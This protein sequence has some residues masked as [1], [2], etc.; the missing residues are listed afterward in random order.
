MTD[1]TIAMAGCGALGSRIA[2]ELARPGRE[3]TL[4]DDDVIEE[5]NLPT[6][7]FYPHHVGQRK[8]DSLIE[9]LYWRSGCLSRT[10]P[11][12]L[13]QG[14]LHWFKEASLVVVTFDNAEARNLCNRLDVPVVQVG[15]SVDTGSVH[16]GVDMDFGRDEH[17]RGE[18]PVCTGDLALG[19]IRMTVAV[20]V[21]SIEYW[22]ETGRGR[23]ILVTENDLTYY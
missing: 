19:L 5:R 22:L 3:F 4:V 11:R 17:A 9:M 8:V 10:I 12:T 7:V 18:N 20:A 15:M 1:V 16:W 21:N 6:T 13:N 2:L 14:R 23:N